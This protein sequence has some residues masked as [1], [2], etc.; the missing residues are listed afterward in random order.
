MK[1][2]IIDEDLE[3]KLHKDATN[4]VVKV[5]NDI[6]SRKFGDKF[7]ERDDIVQP[8]IDN[9]KV[10]KKWKKVEQEEKKAKKSKLERKEKK[11]EGVVK[12]EEEKS[13][14]RGRRDKNHKDYS[15]RKDIIKNRSKNGKESSSKNVKKRKRISKRENK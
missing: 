9:K 8:N 4:A 1:K 5:F 6:E 12:E 13:F 10:F 15:K 11:K 2:F 14:Y 3:R 7:E